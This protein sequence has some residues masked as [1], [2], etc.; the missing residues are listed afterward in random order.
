[1]IKVREVE[2]KDIIPLTEFLPKSFP[3]TTKEFWVHLFDF[4]WTSNPAYIPQ[5][6][7]GWVVENDK[8]LVG[9]MGNIP[10][11]F[12]INGEVR[13]AAAAN[14]WYV[15]SSFRGEFSLHL[16]NEFTE[17]KSASLFLFKADDQSFGKI[18]H[19]YKFEAHILPH[20]QKEYFY[21][22]DKKKV[23][24]LI[25]KFFLTD[26]FQKVPELWEFYRRAG[27]LIIAYLHQKPVSRGGVLPEE[28][29]TSSLCTS[30][31][32]AFYRL[33]KPY[34]STCTIA[35]SRD[36]KTL[37]WLYFSSGRSYKRVVIQ[38]H[39]SRDKTLAGYMVFDLITCKETYT[40]HMKLVDI[41]IENNDPQ[42]LTSLTSFAIDFGKQ[43]NV[44]VLSVWANSSET[45]TYFQ[46]AF[47][48]RRAAQHYRYIRF[49]DTDTMNSGRNTHGI[50]CLPMIY[51]PQ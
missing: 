11:K 5:F 28:A 39:R 33:W 9:F 24:T 14:S 2:D 30:C 15:D 25:S 38:C 22:L 3:I 45:E 31:D 23:K 35:L 20:N 49:S 6:P 51:P 42:V 19:K 29:Y 44:A 16:F 26:R 41:C 36:K 13:I 37:N 48:M 27:F 46:R 50:V 21:I 12:L 7:R 47:T 17:Q 1:M 32:D 34:L 4:W 18:L 40:E 8:T 10:V 43:N